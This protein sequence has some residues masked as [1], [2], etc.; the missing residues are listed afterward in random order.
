[1]EGKQVQ[2]SMRHGNSGIALFAVLLGLGLLG[3]V[4][5]AVLAVGIIEYRTSRD[6][7]AATKARLV[8]DAGVSHAIAVMG[9]PL[10]MRDFDEILVG[11]DGTETGNGAYCGTT[12]PQPTLD[13][14]AQGAPTGSQCMIAGDTTVYDCAA[15]AAECQ[16]MDPSSEKYAYYC[17][18]FSED[19]S[20]SYDWSCV[21]DD[22]GDDGV[23]AGFYELETS[24]ELPAEGRDYAEGSYQVRVVND[25]QDP[26]GDP[27]NDTNFRIV[28]IA[29]GESAGGATAEVKALLEAP[30]Y[31]AVVT[32]GDLWI[33]ANGSIQGA[34]AGAHANGRME[35]WTNKAL[36]GPHTADTV[37]HYVEDPADIA[38]IKSGVPPINVPEIDP[39]DYC[40]DADYI[41]RDGWKINMTATP[42][43][44]ILGGGTDWSWNHS[45]NTYKLGGQPS[46]F[47]TF[48][49][50]GNVSYTASIGTEAE[51]VPITLLATGS[52]SIGGKSRIAPA[53]PDGLLIVSGGDIYV[54]GQ[55]GAHYS[56]LIYAENQCGFGGGPN[57]DAL[58]LCYDE[59]DTWSYEADDFVDMNEVGGSTIITYDCSGPRQSPRVTAW[60]E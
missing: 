56:G 53:H 20:W 52:V 3:T 23:L 24:E 31:P 19:D 39:L 29:R 8:A 59:P 22:V 49:V 25:A 41:L 2:V 45:A 26:S 36:Y 42:D 5:A 30:P 15:L 47:G 60:W 51:P 16:A 13:T 40:S 1:M 28:T 14:Q 37:V 21:G 27:F 6:Y 50:H 34:C 7:L 32:N 44:T 46:N 17:T 12:D 11:A 54:G 18:G 10:A 58:V 57:V 55:A 35:L 4:A 33:T 9:G 38:K 43:S 48:C